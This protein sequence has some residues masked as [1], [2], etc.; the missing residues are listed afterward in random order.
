MLTVI[1]LELILNNEMKTNSYSEMKELNVK[2]L[3]KRLL[4]AM[5]E[6]CN[7][8]VDLCAKNHKAWFDSTVDER[9][10]TEAILNTKTQIK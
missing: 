6:A 10:P 4:T 3:R 1:D 8:T 7:Q 2:A 9:T 5:R